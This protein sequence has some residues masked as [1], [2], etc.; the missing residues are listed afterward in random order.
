MAIS[1]LPESR[2][3]VWRRMF[4]HYVFRT[5]GDPVPY[6]PP[7]KRGMLGAMN[8]HLEAYLRIQ[9]VRSLIR[10]LPR[11]QAEQIERW[12]T[13]VSPAAKGQTDV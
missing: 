10:P 11:E 13:A 2:R 5:N 9:I 8:P 3:E 7:D 1:E 4:D 12:V 6:L